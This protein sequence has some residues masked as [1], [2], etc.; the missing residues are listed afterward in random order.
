MGGLTQWTIESLVEAF[1]EHL[2]SVRGARSETRRAYGRYARQFLEAVF[3]N[4]HP[5]APDA[6]AP[7]DVVLFIEER[8]RQW[9]PGS[10]KMIATALR[11]FFR[12]LGMIGAGDARLGDAVPTV[13]RWRLSTLP[14]FLDEEQEARLLASFDTTTAIG[15]RDRAITVCLSALGLRA[16]ELSE[17]RLDDI[18]WRAGCVRIRCRKTRRGHVLP[19]PRSVG[20]AIVGY[21]RDDRPHTAERRIFLTYRDARALSARAV[22]DVVR[23]ALRRAG[24]EG[25]SKTGSHTLRHTLATRMIRRG[26]SLVEIADVL[27]HRSLNTTAIYAK[28]DLLSLTQA[29]LPWPEATS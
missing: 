25:L 26:A 2:R 28:V 21:L 7:A 18:D 16:C 13:A 9:S 22:R 15:R 14:R 12:F 5:I 17:L 1:D 27:G 11:S 20:L 29:A 3:S 6:I 24:I 4:Q 8:S 10:V 23:V 19:L